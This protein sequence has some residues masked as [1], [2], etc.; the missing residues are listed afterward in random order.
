MR[1][2]LIKSLMGRCLLKAGG[3]G[4]AG[5]RNLSQ[6]TS[7]H[8]VPLRADNLQGA[9]S[10]GMVRG[11]ASRGLLSQQGLPWL[12]EMIPYQMQPEGCPA[13]S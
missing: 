11:A 7:L 2:Q 5:G 4:G 6:Q 1:T 12:W 8:L 13:T 10:E 9:G 3:W